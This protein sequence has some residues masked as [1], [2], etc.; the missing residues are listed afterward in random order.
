MGKAVLNQIPVKS[1]KIRCNSLEIMRV[2]ECKVYLDRAE[3]ANLAQSLRP[4]CV[5]LGRFTQ[6]YHMWVSIVCWWGQQNP[7]GFPNGWFSKWRGVLWIFITSHDGS[8]LFWYLFG[9]LL[10][11]T[12]RGIKKGGFQNGNFDKKY[13]S[14]LGHVCFDTRLGCCAEGHLFASAHERSYI[15]WFW[16]ARKLVYV[17]LNQLSLR[18]GGL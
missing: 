2:H 4:T 7:T 18:G 16:G 12:Q 14:I 10:N 1:F 3:S 13:L 8:H 9:C 11:S 15:T 5:G 17:R 6:H